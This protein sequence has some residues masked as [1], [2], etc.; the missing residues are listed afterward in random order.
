[1]YKNLLTLVVVLFIAFALVGCSDEKVRE[2]QAKRIYKTTP[3]GVRYFTTCVEGFL[4]IGTRSTH[5]YNQLAGP[6][7]TCTSGE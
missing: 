3:E 2:Q 1:M 5:G 6:I 7:G 4:F